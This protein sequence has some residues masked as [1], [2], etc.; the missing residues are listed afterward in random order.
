M[1]ISR[2]T[3]VFRT[4]ILAALIWFACPLP[5]HAMEYFIDTKADMDTIRLVFDQKNL[6]GTVRRTGRNQVTISFPENS[7]KNEKAPTPAPL[8]SLRIVRSIT[9]GASSITIGTKLTGFG[10]IRI[11]AGN[12]KMLIQFF[13]DPIGSKWRSPAEKAAREA[14]RKKAARKKAAQKR[15][16]QK[17][18]D[19]AKKAAVKKAESKPAPKQDPKPVVR[20]QTQEPPVISEVD[21][22]DSEESSVLR[23]ELKEAQE[24][25]NP[26]KQVAPVRRPFYSVPYTYRAP[27]ANVGPGEAQAVDTSIPPARAGGNFSAVS[28]GTA[29]DKQEAGAGAVPSIP[30]ADN[31]VSGSARR[32]II[33]PASPQPRG[34]VSG[35]ITPPKPIET[36]EESSV[37]GSVSPPQVSEAGATGQVIPPEP[38]GGGQASGQISPPDSGA[39][40]QVSPPPQNEDSFEA[41]EFP[42]EEGVADELSEFG[43]EEYYDSN[44]TEES[45]DLAVEDD[46][47]DAYPVDDGG[48]LEGEEGAE[49]AEGGKEMTLEEK[50]KIANGIL[51]ASEG[52]LEDG[53][54]QAA[55]DGFKEISLLPYA[56][57]EMRLRALY[58]KAEALTELHR[59]DLAGNFGEVASAWME[60]MNADT[61]APNVPMALLNLGLLNLKVGN[62]P[63]AKAYFNLLK[64]QYPNDP[65][66]PYI[67]Y[68]WG[69]YYL[70]MEEYEKA[71]DQF[72]YLVQMYPDSKVVRDAALGL[73]K[74]LD[75]LGYDEQAY[76]IIDYID[77]RWPRFYIEDLGF[78]L[79]AA[80]TQN[81]LGKRDDAL[82]NYWAYYNLSPEAKEADI[83]LA[84]IGD[85]YLKEGKKP[86][87]KQIYEKAAKDFPEEE[88]GLVS[89]MRLAEEGIYD[90]PSMNEMDKV[91][92]RP[93]NLRPQ[94]I[95][96]LITEKHPDSPLAPLAQLKL[97]MWYY[98][99]KKYGDCLSAVQDFLKKYPRS[100]LSEKASELGT[101]V[102][103]RAV[104]E[105]VKDENYG[106][107]INYWNNY[108]KKNNEGKDVSDETRMGVALSFAKKEQPEKALELIDRYL[109]DEEVPKYSAMALDMALGI[110]VDEQA[111]SK[112]TELVDRAKIKWKLDPRQQVQIE[113]AEAM[114]F[115]NLGETEQSTPLWAGL[116]ANLLLPESSRAYAMYYMA[117]SSMKKKELKKVFIYAQ[118]ALAMLLETGGDR[119]KI[120][121]CILM[122]IF[123]AESSGRYREALKWAAEYD[124]YIPVSDSEWAS[125]RFRLAQLY[126]KAGAISEW[127]KLMEEV[128]EKSSDD[129]YGRLAKSALETHKI[130]QE[131][132]KFEPA[133]I[134][135]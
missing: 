46:A 34:A 52:A 92:D 97:G 118:E 117:K 105:L 68:Y 119:E 124:K 61:K 54:T 28:G 30:Q 9:K 112:V 43:E 44:G 81:R 18:A 125:S 133:P 4:L 101:K 12:G 39:S 71:A 20:K 32:Q 36:P 80:N 72:Q 132:S 59:E 100:S 19:A 116:A 55:V 49:G 82:E 74:A 70:G 33:P 38:Q 16:A 8:S 129:L 73:A 102:F 91:F 87:A 26:V 108:A 60:A 98:W 113:Y 93:Y 130:E 13:R 31:V 67:S 83:V 64:S 95:Y 3:G 84:R 85:I 79:M 110:Y 86:A 69:E 120:K 78:L 123:A 22:P 47:S 122:T 111:W 45:E 1:T 14:A 88:G 131:A 115:E 94:K 58:G 42:A 96:T 24:I 35:K 134:F 56:P 77:K 7:L 121:D 17:K 103:D 57:P 2:F 5:G 37:S 40:G 99:N 76:Q 21:L 10:F 114:A 6:S 90:D 104:P 107:V 89:M 106:R 48:Q 51:L 27:V 11:P 23:E 65:N 29:V 25:K 75:K 41:G 63:E 62:M 53:E 50:L 127:K 109:Q 15:A 128:A 135:Q 126:E 66:I